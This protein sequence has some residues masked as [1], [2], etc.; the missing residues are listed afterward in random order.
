M[1]F[2]ESIADN[3]CHL[4]WP[5]DWQVQQPHAAFPRYFQEGNAREETSGRQIVGAQLSNGFP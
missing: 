2:E 4:C 3:Q 1:N 5:I